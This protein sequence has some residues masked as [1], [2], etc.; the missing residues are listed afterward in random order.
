MLGFNVEFNSGW[1]Q[2]HNGHH[3]EKKNMKSLIALLGQ[4]N[5]NNWPK[6]VMKHIFIWPS[7]F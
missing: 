2:P 7:N 6:T 1:Y 4:S 5:K 3:F